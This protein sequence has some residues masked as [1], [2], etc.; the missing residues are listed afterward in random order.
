[1]TLALN[2]AH[3]NGNGNGNGNAD[4]ILKLLQLFVAFCFI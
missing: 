4:A 2:V 1:L 3:G